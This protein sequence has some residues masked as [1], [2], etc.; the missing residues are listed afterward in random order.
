ME[1]TFFY[2]C[3]VVACS[4]LIH[5]AMFWSCCASCTVCTCDAFFEQL[6]NIFAVG[7]AM[8]VAFGSW[9]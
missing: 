9:H 3:L 4:T 6:F 5:F 1:H 2:V 7:D 8:D